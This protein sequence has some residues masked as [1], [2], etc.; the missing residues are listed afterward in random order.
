MGAPKGNKFWKLRSDLSETG[1]KL[2][3]EE[4]REKA[5]EYID[6][7]VE[8]PLREQDFRGRDLTEISLN[9]MRAMTLEGLYF[10]L[11]ISKQTWQDWKEDEKYIDIIT[12]V[13]NL[14]FTYNFEGAAANMLNPNIIARKLGISDSQELNAKL[15]H[16]GSVKITREIKK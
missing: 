5:Q 10:H 6:R 14:F 2:T 8:E 7:C 4:I 3:P 15:K 9:K 16:S 11:Q 1:K 13:E 12:H